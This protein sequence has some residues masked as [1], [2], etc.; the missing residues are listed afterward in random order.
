MMLTIEDEAMV[1]TPCQKSSWLAP[2][3]PACLKALAVIHFSRTPYRP[4]LEN[5]HQYLA[6]PAPTF[7]SPPIKPTSR[8]V[9]RSQIKSWINFIFTGIIGNIGFSA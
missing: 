9:K 6:S 7:L 2:L 5:P 1:A 3:H 8:I 4:F